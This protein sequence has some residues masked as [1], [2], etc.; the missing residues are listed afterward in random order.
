MV[1]RRMEL[2]VVAVV[3]ELTIITLSVVVLVVSL[4]VGSLPKQQAQV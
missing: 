4:C 2:L 3:V 1:E